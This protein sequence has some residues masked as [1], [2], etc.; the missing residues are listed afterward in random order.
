MCGDLRAV[1][2]A[3]NG[4]LAA[5]LADEAGSGDEVARAETRVFEARI[6]AEQAIVAASHEPGAHRPRR[7]RPRDP[8]G[9]LTALYARVQGLEV[10]GDLP[11]ERSSLPVIQADLERLAGEL[12]ALE[13]TGRVG[14]AGP[15]AAG[16]EVHDPSLRS[17]QDVLVHYA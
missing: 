14:A 10:T 6:A 11:S 8:A 5:L 17:I 9:D 16:V 12:T 4:F 1:A 15:D 3:L 7:R 2:R 13:D